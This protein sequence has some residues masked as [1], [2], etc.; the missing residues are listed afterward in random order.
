[1]DK[2]CCRECFFEP[3]IRE[4]IKDEGRIGNCNFCG[5]KDVFIHDVKYVGGFILEGVERYYEDAARQ[6]G[7]PYPQYS[8]HI[9]TCAFTPNTRDTSPVL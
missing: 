4:Y 3:V 1:M 7:Y 5:G 8:I 9:L 6:V 2:V